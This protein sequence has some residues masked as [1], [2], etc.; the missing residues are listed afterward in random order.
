MYSEFVAVQYRV[1]FVGILL[2][3]SLIRQVGSFSSDAQEKPSKN[4]PPWTEDSGNNTCKCQESN[5]KIVQCI[6]Y[7]S[8]NQTVSLPICYCMSYNQ[9]YNRIVVGYCASRCYLP[10]SNPARDD[11]LLSSFR[12]KIYNWTRN[13]KE[14][15]LFLCNDLNMNRDG[16][17]C[18]RCIKGYG[19]P[20]YSYSMDCQKCSK[21]TVQ[22][23]LKYFAIT[24]FPLTIFYLIAIVARISVTSGAA[25]GY[26]LTSQI[27]LSPALTHMYCTPHTD[28]KVIRYLIKLVTM[29]YGI[30]NLDFFRSLY[31]PFCIHESMNVLQTLSLE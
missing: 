16:Q 7:D 22:N 18:G 4:C 30:W 24:Y 12:Y 8:I 28:N 2:L 15:N 10:A 23:L 21:S 29:Y 3:F 31:T 27:I 11:L 9:D 1:K 5:I 17:L 13:S 25:Y 19:P 20:V 26:I 6:S 14:M